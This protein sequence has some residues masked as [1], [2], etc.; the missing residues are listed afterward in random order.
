[1]TSNHKPA[2][3]T[4]WILALVAASFGQDPIVPTS[5]FPTTT[6]FDQLIVYGDGYNALFDIAHPSS[7]PPTGGWPI[8]LNCHGI[9]GSHTAI[10]SAVTSQAAQGYF[11]IG[12]DIRGQGPLASAAVNAGKGS[13]LMGVRERRDMKELLE[14]V[15][16][17]FPTFAD[18]NR[19]GVV[20]GS[21]GGAHAWMAAAWSGQAVDDVD[22]AA[23]NFPDI[24]CIVAT[25]HSPDYGEMK[26]PG[27]DTFGVASSIAERGSANLVVEPSLSST[28]NGLYQTEAYG[29][30]RT[31]W[32]DPNRNWF[33]RAPSIT[34]PVLHMNAYDDMAWVPDGAW[35]AFSVMPPTTPKK[36]LLHTGGHQS[37][38]NTEENALRAVLQNAWLARFLKNEQNG[39]D[40]GPQYL[41]ATEPFAGFTA[42]NSAWLRRGGSSF[43]PP[44]TTTQRFH[45]APAG[46]LQSS[47]PATSGQYAM[48]QVLLNPSYTAAA[49]YNQSYNPTAMFAA[50]PLQEIVLTGPAFAQ[51]TEITGA[52]SAVL[53]VASTASAWQITAV[54]GVRQGATFRYIS[55]GTITERGAQALV[56]GPRTV[57]GHLHS[58]TV[59]SGSTLEV[60]LRNI[61]LH[62]DGFGGTNIRS[63]PVFT[64]FAANVRFGPSTDSFIDLPTVTTPPILPILAQNRDAADVNVLQTWQLTLHGGGGAA[65]ESAII[66]LSL[67][68][69]AP[70]VVESG[71]DVLLNPD[72]LTQYA[73]LFPTTAPFTNLIGTIPP[74]NNHVGS[75]V[76]DPA[77]ISTLSGFSISAVGAIVDN[78]TLALRGV[79]NPVSIALR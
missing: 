69:M 16:A 48:N 42:T 10:R 5:G 4:F 3:G 44:Q 64:P 27:A 77:A 15:I 41:Y 18:Q 1:M 62:H 51:A 52:F 49:A 30:M 22:P 79:S 25:A 12:Y 7:P 37:P 21:Q 61:S 72:A 56:A 19:I 23:G 54:L 73:I 46:T 68:G 8:I 70:G 65:T 9:G 35:R 75:V 63:T 71:F 28:L 38:T 78:P 40:L 76:L 6:A 11:A 39:A 66:A 24:D 26:I 53:D 2:L 57:S 45:V 74:S 36:L 29:T 17:A 20:G 33:L 60:R 31:L 13:T 32:D 67:S 59:P 47:V 50:L 55:S 43:P 58:V 34:V 14:F